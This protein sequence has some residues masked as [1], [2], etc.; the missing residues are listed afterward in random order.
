VRT[1]AGE[2]H[3]RPTLAGAHQH[4]NV[5]LAVLAAERLTGLGF[6]QIDGAAIARGVD[7]CRWLGRLELVDLPTGARVL[8]DGA[9]NP[10]GAAALAAHLESVAAPWDLVFGTLADKDAAAM[11]ATLAPSARRVFL[12]PP[13][14]P[15]ALRL[16]TLAALP[17]LLGATPTR[18]AG[19]ALEA[20]LAAGA[21]QVVVTG[22]LYLVG[23]ARR[24]LRR[25][26]GVPP[27]AAEIPAWEPARGGGA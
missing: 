10:A 23:E 19:E 5:A 27:A 15:R 8:L 9:H 14:S 4:R 26:H 20:A 3:L 21:A 7:G 16:D 22:S 6:A 24:W 1:T 13:A 11:A 25:H 17:A 12:A 18:G 2:H